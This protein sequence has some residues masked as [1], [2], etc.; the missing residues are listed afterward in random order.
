M[1]DFPRIFIGA[2]R[3]SSGKTL[4]SIGLLAAFVR[5]GLTVQPFKKGPDYIDPRWLAAAAGRD[6]HNLD[7]FMMGQE[8]ILNNF[9]RYAQGADLSLLE[10]NMG[11]FDGQDLQGG[12]CGAALA[13]LLQ[14]PV[15]LVVDCQGL[16]R[17]VAP[18][19]AGHLHFPGGEWIQGIVL[20]NLASARQEKKLVDALQHYCPVPILGRLPRDR[21]VAIEERHLG[22]EPAGERD[23]L[24]QRLAAMGDLV[25]EHLDL[26]KI[27]QLA[28]QAPALEPPSAPLPLLTH[29]A[30]PAV[31]QAGQQV[32]YVTDRAFHFYYPENLQALREEGVEL[33]PLSFL[34]RETVPDVAGLYIGGGFPEMF[35]DALAA[36]QPLMADLRQKIAAGLPVYAECGGLMVLAEEMHWQGHTA[37]MIGALPI[38]IRMGSRPQGY[39]YMELEGCQAGVWPG[40]GRR[41]ACHE[42]HY[43]QV[44][45]IGAEVR[46]AYRVVR[47][48]GIDGQ[49]DGLLFRNV[50]ASYAHIHADAAPGWARFLAGFWRS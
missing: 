45:R 43:S 44:T 31:G 46:F 37:P 20:N 36:N 29:I 26:E 21:M 23:G 17:G 28:R 1:S 47:G 49:H 50:L 10:G 42:F 2:T 48:H 13:A 5:R 8:V 7:F 27:L 6:C 30:H 32:A 9:F 35:M 25:A 38:A 33:L 11:L 34:N 15:L 19:V 12:D 41:V 39:G 16:A 18:L 40:P 22:L 3:K 4:V 14:T 24:S